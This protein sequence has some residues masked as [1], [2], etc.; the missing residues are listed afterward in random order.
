M[1]GYFKNYA[2]IQFELARS[3][4]VVPDD[5]RIEWRTEWPLADM[6]QDD[7][8]VLA[9]KIPLVVWGLVMD[10]TAILAGGFLR[11]WIDEADMTDCDLDLFFTSADDKRVAEQALAG[12]GYE[13]KFRCPEGKLTTFTM[14]RGSDVSPLKVQCVSNQYYTDAA[15]V[16]D[17]FDLTVAQFALHRNV[18]YTGRLSLLHLHSRVMVLHSLPYPLATMRRFTQYAL[19]GFWIPEQT[20]RDFIFAV[21]DGTFENGTPAGIQPDESMRWYID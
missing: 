16:I 4:D 6:W 13:E 15:H 14:D 21:R 7:V 2:D 5:E 18:L 11:R 17:T 12:A 1:I 9:R 8:V 3:L 20:A 10:G 19:K